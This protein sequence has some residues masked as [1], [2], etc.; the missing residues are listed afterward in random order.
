[1]PKYTRMASFL[2]LHRMSNEKGVRR[3]N[4][5]DVV[6]GTIFLWCNDVLNH[7]K[8]DTEMQ[9]LDPILCDVVHLINLPWPRISGPIIVE[10][11][12]AMCS[13]PS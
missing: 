7:L 5:G 13:L 4:M 1:M 8:Y 6:I 10:R 2:I 12:N 9:S 11:D 3:E